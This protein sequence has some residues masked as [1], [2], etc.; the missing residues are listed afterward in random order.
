MSQPTEQFHEFIRVLLGEHRIQS[1]MQ[2]GLNRVFLAPFSKIRP[3]AV[4]SMR[5]DLRSTGYFSDGNIRP[6]QSGK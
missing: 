2:L 3:S 6:F 5:E 1:E 4:S